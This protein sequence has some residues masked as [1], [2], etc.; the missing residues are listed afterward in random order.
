MERSFIMKKSLLFTGVIL[1]AIIL[2]ELISTVTNNINP[3]YVYAYDPTY[4]TTGVCVD[5]Y[6]YYTS[7][8][9]VNDFDADHGSSGCTMQAPP[10]GAEF[11]YRSWIGSQIYP[12]ATAYPTP[13]MTDCGNGNCGAAESCTYCF[14][15]AIHDEGFLRVEWTGQNYFSPQFISLSQPAFENDNCNG[16]TYPSPCGTPSGNWS[17]Y[18]YFVFS[19]YCNYVANSDAP[20]VSQTVSL[21]DGNIT[22]TSSAITVG[23]QGR[24]GALEPWIYHLSVSLNY[25]ANQYDTATGRYFSVSN[26]A[27]VIIPAPD[28]YYSNSS[29]PTPTINDFSQSPPTNSLIMY[30]DYLTLGASTDLPYYDSPKNG[31]VTTAYNTPGFGVNPIAGALISWTDL[32]VTNGLGENAADYAT[33]N[34]NYSSVS[35]VPVTAYHIY[36]SLA[37]SAGVG[38]YISVG[39]ATGPSSSPASV[40]MFTDTNCPGGNTFCYKV[41]ACNNGPMAD[42]NNEKTNTINAS[43]NEPLLNATNV[44]EICGHVLAP[45]TPTPSYTPVLSPTITPTFCSNCATAT[46]TSIPTFSGT[47]QLSNAYVYPNPFNPNGSVNGGDKFFHVG[48]VADGTLIHIYSMDGALVFDGTYTASTGGFT[49]DGTNKNSSKVVSGLYYLVLKDPKSSKTA[50][51]RVIVCYKCDPVYKPQ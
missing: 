3:P 9:L 42:W 51:F 40:T 11:D 17:K 24:S 23:I 36:R 18:G 29:M 26:I 2:I 22:I 6:G 16:S 31:N 10:I 35:L 41:L 46:P 49:W 32:G 19:T 7:P 4:P 33:A 45:A 37:H 13:I 48:N 47:P 15:N 14:P 25:L 30:Y 12:P 44:I 34:S 39:F 38:P 50:V 1:A 20:N 8:N 43:Y 28:V 27:D 5:T 21:Y